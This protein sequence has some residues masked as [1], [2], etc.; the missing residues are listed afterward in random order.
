[1][2]IVHFTL[3][4]YIT[5]SLYI[6]IPIC[7]YYNIFKG[8]IMVNNQ[9]FPAKVAAHGCCLLIKQVCGGMRQKKKILLSTGIIKS[10][11]FLISTA[12]FV[13][14]YAD[15]TWNLVIFKNKSSEQDKEMLV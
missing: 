10:P 5:I 4:H 15:A 12:L 6:Y 1:V 3:Y 13:N 11:A 8:T 9:I 7:L 2:L 14:F